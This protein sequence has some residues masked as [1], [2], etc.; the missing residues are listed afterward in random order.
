MADQKIKVKLSSLTPLDTDARMLDPG[1]PLVG[2]DSTGKEALVV[3]ITGRQIKELPRLQVGGGT[4]ADLTAYPTTTQMNAAIESA[5]VTERAARD[6]QASELANSKMGVD[7]VA[8]ANE[9][10]SQYRVA[11]MQWYQLAGTNTLASPFPWGLN[12][13]VPNT[14]G[15]GVW[16]PSETLYT[17]DIGST[18]IDDPSGNK[19]MWDGA[20]WTAFNNP[21]QPLA[22]TNK[23]ATK[24]I[25]YD[26]STS[27]TLDLSTYATSADMATTEAANLANAKAYTDAQ[28]TLAKTAVTTE[29]HTYT[30]TA[31][32]AAQTSTIASV[33]SYTDS[34]VTDAKNTFSTQADATFL[35][36]ATL[37]SGATN[38]TLRLA[39]NL[40]T[41]TPL[42][43]PVTGLKSAA[44]TDSTAYSPAGAY[45]KPSSGIPE[46][47]LS[48][49]VVSKL[50]G[51][52]GGS[53]VTGLQSA[54][55]KAGTANGTL[56]LTTNGTDQSP[57]TV[58]GLGTAAY[59]SASDF[60]TQTQAQQSFDLAT[61]L[62]SNDTI[63]KANKA[64]QKPITGI[65]TFDLSSDTQAI[66]AQA[67][68]AYQKQATGIP[69]TDLASSVQTS[70]GRADTAYQMPT[71][72]V[73]RTNLDSSTRT[74]L[75]KADTAL[76]TETDPTVP[77][78]AKAAQKPSYTAQEVGAAT[79]AQGA[80]ANTAVQRPTTA[81]TADDIMVFDANSNAK[82]SG[83][84]IT[85]LLQ[86]SSTSTLVAGNALTVDSSGNIVDSGQS[87]AAMGGANLVQ[88][89]AAVAPSGNLMA[90]DANNNAVDSGKN[91]SS[92]A[93]KS[94]TA[95]IPGSSVGLINYVNQPVGNLAGLN[96]TSGSPVYLVM[97]AVTGG[98]ILAND[99]VGCNGVI[100]FT[101]INPA[102]ISRANVL[103]MRA[104]DKY[105]N[106]ASILSGAGTNGYQA[107]SCVEPIFAR[108]LSTSVE[109]MV[110]RV[111]SNNSDG[112]VR[113]QGDSI[114]KLIETAPVEVLNQS[115][116]SAKYAVFQ[117]CAAIGE[118]FYYNVGYEQQTGK[119]W[120]DAT[121][122]RYRIFRATYRTTI[123]SQ[124]ATSTFER[125]WCTLNNVQI[126]LGFAGAP[127]SMI[128]A[129]WSAGTTSYFPINFYDASEGLIV[130]TK[131]DL[132]NNT[133]RI[134]TK[135][136]CK[137][138]GWQGF[139]LQP[140]SNNLCCTFYYVKSNDV[141]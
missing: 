48:S 63:N 133:L 3:G 50:N 68:T 89:P 13:W 107:I 77:A 75:A 44:Y 54:S 122:R 74:S 102:N 121:G 79:T 134:A 124:G 83:K 27:K 24:N 95:I 20:K 32:T 64:Y 140:N 81:A 11:G 92:I 66:L 14:S 19:M 9:P 111:T 80:L 138:G 34:Q 88:K 129:S 127:A 78:W 130:S 93:M 97:R 25:T 60:V 86:K 117:D 115:Q 53:T 99:T 106:R 118:D 43:V 85:D 65:P 73:A 131:A 98:T 42:D 82:D 126:F 110:F 132:Q 128:A 37:Q 30:D 29:A 58:P 114:N 2:K 16:A 71:T 15:G 1:E 120:T 35:K 38:G 47:D 119:Y 116:F 33:K 12:V 70:L 31:I 59:Q 55:L 6:T 84:K 109:Y 46:G 61:Q 139:N 137:D 113:F 51:I 28:A 141:F 135:V 108:N 39:T 49:A 10:P 52:T 7:F 21:L 76:Q 17:P 8:S 69:L 101:G 100:S 67:T 104:Q 26:G 90:F 103:F 136:N 18:R 56:V 4:G 125:Q 87:V 23:D 62:T 5:M 36:S 40:T 41:G 57:V 123:A 91:I 96:I 45:V 112:C 22:V 94:E 105:I 72:G